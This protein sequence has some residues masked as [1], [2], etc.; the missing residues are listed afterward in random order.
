MVLMPTDMERI[1]QASGAA[2]VRNDEV[3]VTPLIT[4][5]LGEDVLIADHGDAVVGVV[6]R[7]DGRG[8]GVDDGALEGRE[9]KGAELALA[10]V[11]GVGI[12]AL[13]GRCKRSL[14]FMSS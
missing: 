5:D 9:V 7:H 6:G 12:D 2:R 14:N 3:L 8:A 4:E 1:I 10:A 11:D 13:L